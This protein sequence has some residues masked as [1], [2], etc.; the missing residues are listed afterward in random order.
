LI[1][2]NL[3]D[4]TFKI[5]EKKIGNMNL[6][7]CI[8]VK[9]NNYIFFGEKGMYHLN[10][11]P[12]KIIDQNYNINKY[13]INNDKKYIDGIKINDNTVALSS[14]SLYSKGEDKLIFYNVNKKIIT[15]EIKNFS[16]VSSL[17]G[18]SL[19]DI[20]NNKNS[21]DTI[22]LCACTK[23]TNFQKNGILLV[24][25][26]LK[27]N[28]EVYYHFHETDFEVQCFCPIINMKN[29]NNNILN[30][31][32]K[33]MTTLYFLA[34]GFDGKKGIGLIQLF[35]IF[36]DEK[37][38][39]YKIEFISEVFIDKQKYNINEFNRINCITQSK[40]TGD[41]LITCKENSNIYLFNFNDE[42]IL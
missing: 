18:F 36:L 8:E 27:N 37:D 19:I 12:S 34:G 33:S 11:M 26:L 41:I 21:I 1:K 42:Q 25:T 28:E 38:L 30:K 32:N 4:F 14:N 2:I 3:N 22:L 17:N 20:N 39:H 23:Y 13:S 31:N 29:E 40:K 6:V 10:E 9:D 15:H 35:K 5:F 7:Q 16:F 24:D